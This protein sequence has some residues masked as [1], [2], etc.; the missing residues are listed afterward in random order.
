MTTDDAILTKAD[1]AARY[2]M[3]KSTVD[4]LC[5]RS[6]ESLPPFFKMGNSPNS[7]IR[8]RKADCDAWDEQRVAIQG[9][10][11]VQ[12]TPGRLSD[13]MAL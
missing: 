7:P 4:T 3:K 9:Q 11:D 6:P 8:F 12:R 13:L 1:I 5:S 2:Q 10:E